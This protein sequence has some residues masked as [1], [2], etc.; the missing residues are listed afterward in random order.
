MDKL[1]GLGD[2][3]GMLK[4]LRQL[5]GD[6][7]K[8]QKELAKETVTAEVADGAIKIVI[9]GDQRLTSLEISPEAAADPKLAE[10]LT[11]GF[12]D[13]LE[14]SRQMA[15]DRLGPLSQGLNF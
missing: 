11:E 2:M 5:Q 12:N 8:A 10:L 3:G 14:A 4:Q 15:K 6:L 9:T 13:A 1:P 7:V